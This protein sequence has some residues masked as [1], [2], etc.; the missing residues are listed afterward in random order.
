[1]QGENEDSCDYPEENILFSI[2]GSLFPG[3]KY[4][5]SI[6]GS[7]HHQKTYADYQFPAELPLLSI[8]YQSQRLM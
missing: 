6:C 1:M 5:D 2:E 4:E 3:V 8:Q 7:H